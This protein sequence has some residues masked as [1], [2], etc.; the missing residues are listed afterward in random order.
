MKKTFYLER[1][2][3]GA[4]GNILRQFKE[5][6]REREKIGYRDTPAKG[7]LETCVPSDMRNSE[8]KNSTGIG[9]G[10]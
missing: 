3:K 7:L 1:G 4:S 10:L 6:W 5:F 2:K 8:T 9:R